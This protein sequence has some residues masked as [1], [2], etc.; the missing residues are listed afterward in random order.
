MYSKSY[1]QGDALSVW[2]LRMQVIHCSEDTKTRA[3][4]PLC[5]IFM[6]HRITKVHEQPIPEQ[7]GDVPIVAANHFRTGGMI[8]T[9]DLPV[10]FGIELGGELGRID[11]VAE[12]NR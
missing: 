11:Q 10:L 8:S 5:I 6:R 3:Y 4:S 7:L 12:H 9:D 1:C 2:E